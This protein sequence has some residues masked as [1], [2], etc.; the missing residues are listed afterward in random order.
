M[1][2]DAIHSPQCVGPKRIAGQA[3]NCYDRY[4]SEQEVA[5]IA[6]EVSSGPVW[7]GLDGAALHA[8]HAA[9][10]AADQHKLTKKFQ[11]DVSDEIDL[12]AFNGDLSLLIKKDGDPKQT[13]ELT[14]ETQ[15][16]VLQ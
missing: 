4:I 14:V 7:P 2:A 1:S 6:R 9:T 11:F 5:R 10:D 16:L 12:K 3:F 13:D 15:T 8:G